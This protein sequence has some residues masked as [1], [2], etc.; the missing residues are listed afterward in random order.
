MIHTNEF[1]YI[2]D[3]NPIDEQEANCSKSGLLKVILWIF[4]A[5]GVSKLR[6]QILR[7]EKTSHFGF[8]DTFSYV[9]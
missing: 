8:K 5:Q 1:E 4:V 6:C 2:S 7:T 3:S 9:G